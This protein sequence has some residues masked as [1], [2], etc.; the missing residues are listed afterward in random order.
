MR[1]PLQWLADYVE[2]TLPVDELAHLMTMKG[3]KV[4][5]IERPGAAWDDVVIGQV[6]RLD[7]HPTSNKP[8]WVADVNLG[9]QQITVVTG[10]QNLK[11]GDK[12]PVVLVG[13]RLPFGPDGG[14][15]VIQRRPMAGITSEGMLA[16]Q[17]ELGI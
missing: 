13:G 4:E 9:N 16:S 3:L 15:M 8:L 12:A 6:V 14:P 11:Q 1:V 5:A 2:I 10:A 7:P 17:R